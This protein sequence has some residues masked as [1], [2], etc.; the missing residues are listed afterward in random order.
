MEA[1][2]GSEKSYINKTPSI[3]MWDEAVPYEK[4]KAMSE[5]L[6]DVY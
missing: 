1:T 5:Y 6:Q 3:E 2:V 4:I